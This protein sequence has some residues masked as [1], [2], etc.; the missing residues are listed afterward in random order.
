MGCTIAKCQKYIGIAMIVSQK[1]L[2]DVYFP[3][4]IPLHV[5]AAVMDQNRLSYLTPGNM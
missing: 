1:V 2:M 4:N 3:G 5:F